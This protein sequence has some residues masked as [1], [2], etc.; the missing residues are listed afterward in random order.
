MGPEKSV[1]ARLIGAHGLGDETHTVTWDYAHS[2]DLLIEDGHEDY[3]YIKDI[4]HPLI[5]A[6]YTHFSQ[7]PHHQRRLDQ[8][9][10]LWGAADLQR[11]LH[12]LFE[13]RFVA[14]EYIA[15]KNFLHDLPAIFEVLKDELDIEGIPT[16]KSTKIT[17]WLRT[18][19]QFKFVAHLIML[20]DVYAATK[21]FSEQSQSDE[22]LIIDVPIMRQAFHAGLEMLTISLG[23]EALH[24][25]SSLRDSKLVMAE[26]G[27]VANRELLLTHEDGAI[28]VVGEMPLLAASGD[29]KVR[30][31]KYQK[32]FVRPMLEN[33]DGRIQNKRVAILLRTIFDFRAMPLDANA[34]SDH[35]LLAWSDASI[36]ELLPAYFPEIDVSTFK[37]EALAA[38]Y[39]AREHQAR[40][41]QLKDSEDASK[42]K[43]FVLTG[44]GGLYPALFSRSDVCSKP[45]PNFLHVLDYMISFSWQ[46]CCGE[47]AGSYINQIKTTARTSLTPDTLDCLAYNAF[48]MP[49]LHEIDFKPVIK[50]WSEDGRL[51]GLLKS[52][53]MRSS[54]ESKV[55]KRHLGEA[56]NTFLFTANSPYAPK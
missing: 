53:P 37:D 27:R 38:R 55:I 29:L 46:S 52:D 43:M 44:S 48:N 47:R 39:F 33:F 4:V 19:K 28:E 16:E 3:P 40:F 32:D 11:K 26:A 13:V 5:K 25:L 8:L 9:C 12:Y 30:M 35:L 49:N 24:R 15:I 17:G 56:K 23:S 41:I 7:S 2:C 50:K 34:A 31:L 45:I 21:L 51:S 10:E 14:S 18:M 1:R 42:G 6:V 20:I 22:S 36:D 54:A